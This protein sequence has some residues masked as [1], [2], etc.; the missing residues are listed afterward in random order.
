[1]YIYMQGETIP[2]ETNT[3]QSLHPTEKDQWGIPLLVTKV[4]YDDNDRKAIERFSHASSAE[5]L[6]AIGGERTSPS[7]ITI[8]HPDG[9]SMKWAD[10]AWARTPKRHCSTGIIKYTA[11]RMFSSPTG[12]A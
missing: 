12:P 4:D 9:I 8:G 2:K 11:V 10:V 5:M 1:M 7:T 6:D 3:V